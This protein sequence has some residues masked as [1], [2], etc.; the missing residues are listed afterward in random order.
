VLLANNDKEN[1]EKNSQNED[2]EDEQTNHHEQT[3][4]PIPSGPTI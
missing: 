2:K 1:R 4:T 3:L